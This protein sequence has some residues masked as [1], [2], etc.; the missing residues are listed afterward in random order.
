MIPAW[1]GPEFDGTPACAEADPDAWFP[2]KGGTN[3][4]AKAVCRGCEVIDECL[5]WA[6][7]NGEMHGVWGG[8][9][10]RERRQLR[11]RKGRAA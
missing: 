6:L 11:S 2:D 7:D 9:S 10:E 3:R 4:P 5:T 1:Q 8:L